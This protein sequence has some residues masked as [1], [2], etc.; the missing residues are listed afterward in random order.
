[1]TEPDDS[2]AALRAAARAL[3]AW[4]HR[5]EIVDA[6]RAN[7]VVVV[8]GPTG[9]GKTTQLPQM[10]LDEGIGVGA[11]ALTQPR[12]I[13]A[14]SIAWR[15]A[16]EMGVQ[17][18]HEVGYAIRFDD[19]SSETSRVRV[20]TDGI[21]LQEA[22]SDPDF[23]RYG[24]IIVDEA[25][26]RTLNI[27]F[28]LGLLHGA[29]RRRADLRL[30]ISSATLDPGRFQAFY[31][32]LGRDVPAVSIDARPHPVDI[33]NRPWPGDDPRDVAQAMAAELA[34]LH[35][36]AP[37]GDALAFFS[38]AAGI[39][40]ATEALARRG[41]ANSA[42]LVPLY[43][44]LP[45]E[46]QE[47]VFAQGDGRRRIILATNIAET[48]ITVP[49]VRYV[50]D[51]GRAKVARFSPVSGVRSLREEGISQASAEQR[52]GRAGR[53]A[54]GTAVRMYN[55][56]WLKR[57]PPFAD[58]EVLREDLR[59]VVL[60]LVD[61]GVHDLEQ[62]PFPTQPPARRLKAAIR[63]LKA[64][65]AID[66]QRRLTTIGRRMVP[67]P[68]SPPLA[69]AVV[70]AADRHPKA[71]DAVLIA[72]AFLSGR[73]PQTFPPEEEAQARAAHE[74]LAHPAG[75]AMTAVGIM[76]RYQ[77]ARDKVSYCERSYLDPQAMAYITNAHKQ[78]CELAAEMGAEPQR[79]DDDPAAVI[80]SLYAG[81]R[82]QVLVARGRDWLGPNDI[83]LRIHPG[84]SMWGTR[85]RLLLAAD[86]I[87]LARPYAAQVSVMRPEWL[88][89]IDP[90]AARS[91]NIRLPKSKVGRKGAVQP[92]EVP[93][94]AVVDGIELPVVIRRGRVQ[95][96]IPHE[97]VED[98]RKADADAIDPALARLKARVVCGD[99]HF[100][101]GTPL[102]TLVRLL[103]VLPLPEPGADLSCRVPEGALLEADR[104]LHTL[105]RHLDDLLQPMQQSHGRRAGWSMLVGNGAGAWWFEVVPDFVEALT[106][107]L[108]GL[109]QLAEALPEDQDLQADLAPRIAWVAE[110]VELTRKKRGRGGRR[111]GRGRGRG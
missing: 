65:G 31:A 77:Q 100:A 43:G 64:M 40:Q 70:E 87:V 13:A 57:Q 2:T 18:G 83:Q 21:L 73:R 25:H 106:T 92:E 91:L 61:L 89:E 98:L 56:G 55:Q 11:I 3:P 27:D 37:P 1:M 24:V 81:F 51:S 12:R 88:A 75:D 109:E 49:G 4:R 46:E 59:E 23:E 97:R 35:R 42:E 20:M 108:D 9:S 94:H 104:N 16:A 85:Q 6:V 110:G 68:L 38:G 58:P 15:I 84:S 29:L 96:E 99:L 72:V 52:A 79:G 17:V 33:Q 48:S 53:T 80:K 50:V 66:E 71:L 19:C 32:R 69:R 14:V 10:L 22:R 30:V 8:E 36:H 44:A 26:E 5:D 111:S 62:F 103:P 102:R 76:R 86:I 78:L 101:V 41:V 54:P 74:A 90:E 45:R 60:R 67:F 107:T 95:V 82:E 34:N 105:L 63:Q 39:R 93:S 28:T 7:Q 47:R